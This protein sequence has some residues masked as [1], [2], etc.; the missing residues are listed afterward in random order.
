MT[1][2]KALQQIQ[3]WISRNPLGRR[4]RRKLLIWFSLFSLVPLIVTNTVGYI[5]SQHIIERLVTEYMQGIAKVEA[6]HVRDQIERQQVVL[7]L[8]ASGNEFLSAGA[9]QMSGGSAGE[10]GQA[11]SRPAVQEYLEK[12]LSGL[13]AFDALRLYSRDGRVLITAM[14]EGTRR[15]DIAAADRAGFFVLTPRSTNDPPRFHVVEPLHRQDVAAGYLGGIISA[16]RLPAFLE[17]PQHL[18]GNVHTVI[19][20]EQGR[21][22]FISNPIGP[23]DYLR[24]HPISISAGQGIA[25]YTD[26][27]GTRLIASSAGVPGTRWTF[28]TEMPEAAAVGPLRALRRAS[29]LLEGAFVVLLVVVAWLVARSIVT[30]IRN[31]VGAARRVAAGDLSARVDI[32]KADEL[33]ELGATFND[34]T[35][36]LAQASVRVEQLHQEQIERAQQLATVGEL[37]S[38]VAHEIKNPVVGISNGLD[39]VKRR[40]GHEPVVAPIIDEM[41]RQIARIDSA[42]KDLLS[43][44]R[45]SSPTLAPVAGNQ[46]MQR[47]LRLVQPAA[48]NAGLSMEVRLDQDLPEVLLDEELMTQALV[49]VLMN[50]V[51]ATPTGGKIIVRTRATEDHVEFSVSDTGRGIP[52]G[53]LEQ[54]YKPFFTTRHSGTGLGLSITRETIGHHGGTIEVRSKVGRGTTFTITLPK[55]PVA[56]P[57]LAANEVTV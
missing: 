16:A 51:Q 26:R 41:M 40:L 38:G 13:P 17:I 10:M 28:V 42:V 11:A 30:P 3:G 37:A 47:A 14:R 27:A 9:I 52:P 24:P 57:E 2:A 12:K 56:E 20:D 22:L 1:T 36:A 25:R 8:I 6:R 7:R 48:A 5:Q 43:F 55:E 45:P 46:V 34:M 21:P 49:N 31:L 44:A 54:I 29:A 32:Q 23:I 15:S 50:A 4:L 33:G 35:A 39:L 53:D 19:V 18:A